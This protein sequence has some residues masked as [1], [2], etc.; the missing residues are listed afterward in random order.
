VV[1]CLR[2]GFPAAAAELADVTL[3]FAPAAGGTAEDREFF[4]ANLPGEIRGPYYRVVENGEEA[5]FL[6]SMSIGEREGPGGR[7]TLGLMTAGDSSPLLELSWD[8]ARV[9]EMYGWG[10]GNILAPQPSP[11]AAPVAAAAPWALPGQGELRRFFLGLR[12]GAGL[13]GYAFEESPA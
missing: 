3:Y 13:D 2:A 11:A 10:V 6:V 7:F 5:D 8:Y 1:L 4:D 12:G 9:E